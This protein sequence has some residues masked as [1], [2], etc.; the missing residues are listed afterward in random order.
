MRSAYGINEVLFGAVQGN[1]SGETVAV[2]DAYN[3]PTAL[4]DLNAFS[5]QYGLPQMNQT[6]YRRSSGST[7]TRTR[8]VTR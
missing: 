1:G 5:A 6:A 4:D 2:I 3:Y 8:A 7:R